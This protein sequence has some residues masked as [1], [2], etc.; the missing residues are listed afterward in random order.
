MA[1]SISGST[2]MEIIPAATPKIIMPSIIMAG[3]FSSSKYFDVPTQNIPTDIRKMPK[4]MTAR[5]RNRSVIKNINGLK[6]AYRMPGTAKHIPI[7]AGE[8]PN[9]YMWTAK[10]GARNCRLAAT[11]I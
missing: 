1:S 5:L 4:I 9:R 2:G 7:K 10:E 3:L 8:N 6:A 11:R